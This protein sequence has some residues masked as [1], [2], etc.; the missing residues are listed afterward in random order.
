M[1]IADL[2]TREARS[3][4]VEDNLN[5]VANLFWT[6]DCG[7]IPVLDADDRVIG[8]ITDRDAC[9][10][11]FFQLKPLS[12]VPVAITMTRT[13]RTCRADESLDIALGRMAEHR[14][15]RLPIVD[16]HGKLMGMISLGDIARVAATS[17]TAKEHRALAEEVTRTLA[18]VS[19]PH[20]ATATTIEPVAISP[21][22][23][24]A[25]SKIVVSAK[26]TKKAAKVASA[27]KR[28]SAKKK[29]AKKKASKP[30]S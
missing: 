21:K 9:L 18:T 19:L 15:R 4:R 26:T 12:E 3:C 6:H 23:R 28:S 27:P 22:R 16:G 30:R 2:M 17:G 5:D 24:P 25:K 20:G 14:I 8:M 29:S 13:V 11:A 10:G 7:A 1:K